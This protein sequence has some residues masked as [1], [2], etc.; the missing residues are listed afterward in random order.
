[1][2]SDAAWPSA[3]GPDGHDGHASVPQPGRA[4][5]GRNPYASGQ[6]SPFNQ[7]QHPPLPGQQ[8]SGWLSGS[9]R[10]G[11]TTRTSAARAST[12]STRRARS[13]TQINAQ[14]KGFPPYDQLAHD[15]QQ[16]RVDYE[17]LRL[18]WELTRDI[19]LERDLDQLLHKILMSLFRFVNADRA[20]ILLPRTTARSRRRRRTAA[21]APTLRSRSPPPFSVT[22]RRRAAVLTH[23]ASMDFASSKGKSMI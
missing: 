13:P 15:P 4:R 14:Q 17:R 23:D 9:M 18:T 6:S 3:A 7:A 10:R 2:P 22:S 21:T 11:R 5:P 20:V 16:V 1:M 8:G 12:S 19:G